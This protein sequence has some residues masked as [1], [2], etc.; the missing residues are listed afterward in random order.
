LT[1]RPKLDCSA[2]IPVKDFTRDFTIVIAHRGPAWGLWCSI[3]SCEAQ[4][5]G[6]G[7]NYDYVI[8]H[9]GEDKEDV[10]LQTVH[11][12]LAK[13][14][15][16]LDWVHNPNP[17]SPPDARQLG[18]ELADGK[19]IHYLDNHVIVAPGYFSSAKKT[20]ETTGA[21]TVHSVTK[22]FCGEQTHIEYKLKLDT[23]F[24][25]EGKMVDKLQATEPYRIAAG[26]HG[27]FAV[28]RDT[29][30]RLGGYGPCGL[31]QNY[32]GEELL[33]DLKLAMHDGTNWLD[34]NM[35][36]HH[37]SGKRPYARHFSDDYFKNLM[38]CAYVLGGDK[39]VNLVFRHFEHS[40]KTGPIPIFQLYEEAITHSRPYKDAIER[41]RART[42]DQQLDYFRE[43]NIPF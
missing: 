33:W 40:A 14:G 3:E 12:H 24:W 15:K 20:F 11:M 22:F 43:H 34:P 39:Y 38:I 13:S 5:V 41:T 37:W 35:I 10:E 8:I 6:S 28:R 32:A 16:L 23:N 25:G 30:E 4:L 36:H 26:G 27:G 17:M 19:I 21:D 9:N 2:D 29:W 18:S 7:F 1:H 31:L 42:L